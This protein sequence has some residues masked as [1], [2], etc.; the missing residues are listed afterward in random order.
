MRVPLTWLKDYVSLDGIPV[1]TLADRLTSAGLEVAA[2]EYIGVPGPAGSD[3][4]VWDPGTIRVGEILAVEPHPDADRL[5]LVTVAYGA[6]TPRQ[7]VTGAP[8]VRP[9]L[10]VV[11]A[12][13][14]ATLLNGYSETREPVRLTPRKIRGVQSE[15]MVVSERELGLS[16]EHEGILELPEDAPI[17]M[18]FQEYMGDVV[19]EI[20]L[21]PNLI[22]AAS[23]VGVAREVA[24]LFDRPLRLPE[25]EAQ[26]AGTPVGEAVEIQ[27]DVPALNP[28]FTATLIRDVTVGPSPAWL[29]R[30]LTLAGM[31]PINNVVDAT[32]YV[33]LELG[34]PLHAF[35][36]DRLLARAQAQ[37][38]A[39]PVIIMRQATAGERLTTLDDVERDLDPGDILVTDRAGI[40][41]IAG[42]MG[43]AET[44]VS[45]STTRVLLEA[46]SWDFIATRRSANRH[47]LHSEAAYRFSRGVHPAMAPRGNRRGAALIASLSGG[48]LAPGIVDAYPLPARPVVIE[49]AVSEVERL[50]GVALTAAEIATYLER[51]EFEVEV[52]GERL[53]ATVPDHR[54][55]VTIPADLVEEVG[56]LHGLDRLPATLMADRLPPLRGDRSA[57]VEARIR[58]LLVAAGLTETIS[59][60][61][62]SPEREALLEITPDRNGRTEPPYVRL[63]NPASPDRRV[64]RRNLLASLI[65]TLQ[66]NV[67]QR[68]QVALFEIGAVY[69]PVPGEPLPLEDA[70]LAIALTGAREATT[71]HG[72][73]EPMDYYDV[74]GVVDSLLDHLA[75]TDR[76]DYE[77]STHTGLQPGRTAR[78]LIDGRPVG[79]LGEL[80]PLV[81]RAWE[82]PEQRVAVADLDLALLID[83]VPDSHP[84]VPV[85]R[86]PSIHQDLAVVVAESVPEADVARVIRTAGGE[87]LSELLLFDVYRGASIPEGT[88]S[89]AYALRYQDPELTLTDEQ[90]AGH[91]ARIAAALRDRVSA[92][93]RGED[94]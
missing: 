33:M 34:Q 76:A 31:R 28:R 19:L 93:I 20:D 43:G 50:L 83:L 11:Y 62:T 13:T 44:E 89:L 46:A 7:V 92:A 54:L 47:G 15:G 74:K 51:L 70:R 75:L 17:G 68:E 82:L 4:L 73:S 3:H 49:M 40:L 18:P 9:G 25:P 78:L 48:T 65:E 69:L 1:E 86:V 72:Q 94:L 79:V 59:Y 39:R 91:H 41:S 37:G 81:R 6:D 64:L 16:D 77:A 21:T 23:V 84:I 36:Y 45:E 88:K 71:W 22:R 66:R 26:P 87:T 85:P 55:D 5:R 8:N 52:E 56:R 12:T 42:I 2:I 30:R 67:R 24:A 35:D 60:R 57:K 80:H 32:N 27:I 63:T 58:D 10:R 38:D 29:Q 90:V 14:G 61:M 53:R